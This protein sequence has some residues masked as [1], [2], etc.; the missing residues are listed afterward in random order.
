MQHDPVRE[1]SA[2]ASIAVAE[3]MQVLKKA[4]K[5][6]SNNHGMNVAGQCFG[7]RSHQIGHSGYEFLVVAKHGVAC[8]HVASGILSSDS[9]G[10]TKGKSILGH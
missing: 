2:S 4:V 7:S 9:I 8:R 1:E 3:R 10:D 5:T 6:S